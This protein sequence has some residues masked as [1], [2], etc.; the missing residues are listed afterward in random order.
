MPLGLY[1]IASPKLKGID[2][3]HK[4]SD[5]IYLKAAKALDS[6]GFRESIGVRAECNANSSEAKRHRQHARRQRNLS[7]YA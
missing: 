4:I 6:S 2:E 5:Y 7:A 1:R 3:G